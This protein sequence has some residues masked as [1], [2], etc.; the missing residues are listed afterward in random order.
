MR[1]HLGT[2]Q[3]RDAASLVE[4]PRRLSVASPRGKQSRLAMTLGTTGRCGMTT[5]RTLRVRIGPAIDGTETTI[6]SST[7]DELDHTI[8][9]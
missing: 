3:L 1:I 7:T 5:G 2:T 8:L 4:T 6:S 9:H